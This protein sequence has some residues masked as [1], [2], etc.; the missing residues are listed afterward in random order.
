[1][2]K[3][4]TIIGFLSLQWKNYVV[5]GFFLYLLFACRNCCVFFSFFGSKADKK[6][7][8]HKWN[9]LCKSRDSRGFKR[10]LL[11]MVYFKQNFYTLKINNLT[12][13]IIRIYNFLAFK[14]RAAIGKWIWRIFK[15]LT[16]G[17]NERGVSA[18]GK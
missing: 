17:W 9:F 1:M 12:N 10:S 6:R 4:L 11:I 18:T 2:L 16:V 5:P 15:F 7:A 3:L 8:A 14:S 13:L